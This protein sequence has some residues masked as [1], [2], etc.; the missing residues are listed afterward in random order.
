ML[1]ALCRSALT[2][3]NVSQSAVTALC[4]SAWS[5]AMDL[6]A[7]AEYAQCMAWL[8]RCAKRN[9]SKGGATDARLLRAMS[10][11]D[12]EVTHITSED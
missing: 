5:L 10:I 1:R 6:F 3:A 8:Q 11:V 9:A 7:R 2:S 4:E 12:I